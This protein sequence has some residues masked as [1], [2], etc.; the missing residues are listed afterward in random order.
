M[1]VLRTYARA[2]AS[3]LKE[4]LGPLAS[5]SGEPAGTGFSMPNGLELAA[6]GNVLVVAGDEQT[7]APYRSTQ[8]T[9]IVDDLDE[10][11]VLLSGV[12][13]QVLRGPQQVP[14]GRNLTARLPGGIQIEYVEWDRA[15]WHRVGAPPPR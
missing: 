13:A 7:L 1:R 9:L 4:V 11:Q 10:C 2:Y 6:V 12:G 5:I 8:A 14:T 15:Q 3:G